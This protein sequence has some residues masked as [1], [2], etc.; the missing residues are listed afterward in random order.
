M[1]LIGAFA[2]K[3]AGKHDQQ[4]FEVGIERRVDALLNPELDAH[5]HRLRGCDH[6]GAALDIGHGNFGGSGPRR[7]RD[8]QQRLPHLGETDGVFPDE[9]MVDCLGPHQRRQQ[10][11]KQEG[12]RP[13]ANGE[14]QI[15]HLGGLRAARINDDQLARGI[16]ANVIEM[17]AG[18]GETMRDPRVCTDHQQEI[19]AMHI[20]RG[21][22]GLAAEHMA[23]DP[24]VA[25]F[26]LRQRVE[27]IARTERAQERIGIGAAG[28]VAL[29][30]AAIERQALAA[31]PVDQVSHPPGD[32]GNRNIPPNRIKSAVGA[33]AQRRRE[34]VLVMRIKGDAR[35]LVAE[36][37]LRFRAGT[38]APYLF[39]MPLIDQDFDAAIDIT[40][41][42]GRLVPCA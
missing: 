42:A 9:V 20:L 30:A 27:D 40:E 41:V 33:T 23:V 34:P 24:E 13:R 32:L 25:G 22:T 39:D 5:D 8:I 14:M 4:F 16:L 26:L 38:I 1:Q 6:R 7:H 2:A 28:V 12:I 3:A 17:V 18:I 10:R 37:A 11:A 15:G 29:P 31:V 19:A 35:R 36:I 21:V